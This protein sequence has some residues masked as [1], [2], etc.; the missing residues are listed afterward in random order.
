MTTVGEQI[1]GWLRTTPGGLALISVGVVLGAV[2]FGVA[3]MLTEGSRQ[4]AVHSARSQ[5]EP[6]LLDAVTLYRALSDANSTVTT[7]FL[8]GGLEPPAR[9]AHYLADLDSAAGALQRLT[10]RA[11]GSPAEL[12]P[13]STIGRQLPLYSGLIEAARA[14]N[15]AG[16]PVG[17]AYL[18]QAS[19]LLSTTILPAAR[20]VYEH[21]ARKL[22][23]DYSTG[24]SA[25]ALIVLIAIAVLAALLLVG[26]QIRLARLS[27]RVFNVYALAGTALI[28]ILS[29]WAMIGMATE[30]SALA[31]AHNDG[32]DPVEVLSSTQVLLARAQSDRN[33]TLVARGGDAVDAADFNAVIGALAGQ[34]GLL[35][36]GGTLLRRVGSPGAAAALNRQFA[37]YRTAD[38]KIATLVQDGLVIDAINDAVRANSSGRSPADVL[39]QNLAHQTGA[40]QARFAVHAGDASSSLSGLSLAIPIATV[41]AAAF[42]LLGL[43]QRINEYR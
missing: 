12:R 38:G 28:V 9:R 43:R 21:A 8:I 7:T 42:V 5:T 40:A 15:R 23:D 2:C 31:S 25:T 27:N 30:Q 3:A 19:S 37:A 22:G 11:A 26:T 20:T 41:L 33:L 17:A 14:N 18:R 1:R 35:A 10:A 6:Q 39:A 36:L 34:R 13:L 24:S 16:L 29:A 32:S 4:N